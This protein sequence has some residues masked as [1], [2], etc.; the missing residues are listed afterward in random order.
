MRKKNDCKNTWNLFIHRKLQIQIHS[1]SPMF[2][3]LQHSFSSSNIYKF[4]FSE[5]TL[6]IYSYISSILSIWSVN[7]GF[8][9]MFGNISILNSVHSYCLVTL[10]YTSE[11]Y[12]SEPR[13]ENHLILKKTMVSTSQLYLN[14]WMLFIYNEIIITTALCTKGKTFVKKTV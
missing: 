12:K 11:N 7:F 1:I 2:L 13:Y 6:Y 9:D 5:Q 4:V 3:S 8:V 10:V 14:A